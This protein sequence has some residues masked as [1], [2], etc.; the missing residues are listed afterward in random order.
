MAFD[1]GG[2]EGGNPNTSSVDGR[3]VGTKPKV[4]GTTWKPADARRGAK[5][6]SLSDRV[7]RAGRA[8]HRNARGGA[9]VGAQLAVALS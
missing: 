7:W 8:R 1:L 2:W 3:T 4:G 6:D 5:R 9:R